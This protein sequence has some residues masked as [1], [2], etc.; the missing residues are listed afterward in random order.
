MLRLSLKQSIVM[1]VVIV[2][3]LVA[4]VAGAIRAST[5]RAPLTRYSGGVH[6]AQLTW[7]CPAPPMECS[8]TN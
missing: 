3:L 1:A 5:P 7:Y 2:A 6:G 4:L 8:A